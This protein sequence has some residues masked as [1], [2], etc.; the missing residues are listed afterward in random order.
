MSFWRKRVKLLFGLLFFLFFLF[1]TGFSRK[2]LSFKRRVIHI[3]SKVQEVLY[4]PK[5]KA[6]ES[7]S[8]GYRNALADLLWFKT[9]SYFGK[10]YRLDKDYRWFEKMCSVVQRLDPRARYVVE[11][12]S[13]MLS[14]ELKKPESAIRLLSKGIK[15]DPSYWRYY[16]LRGFTYLY[17]LNNNSLAEKDFLKGSKLS[18]A[19]VFLKR[20]AAKKLAESKLEAAYSFLIQMIKDARDPS[21]KSSL[22]ERLKEV[23]CLLQIKEANLGLK[24]YIKKYKKLPKS[25]KELKKEGLYLRRL[26]DPFGGKLVIN[27]KEKTVVTTSKKGMKVLN[28]YLKHNSF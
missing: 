18:D 4:F 1:L 2:S 9:I 10:H 6:L 19:P 16:Y 12:C 22:I 7:I 17:F 11:F 21:Q 3:N 14:W 15:D 23:E 5:G 13:T 26:K 8:F 25:V 28:S 24:S 27:L 20:I